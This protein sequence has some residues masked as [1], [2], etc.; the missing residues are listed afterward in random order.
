MSARVSPDV[1]G[2]PVR[3]LD[4]GPSFSAAWLRA[5]AFA[6]AAL[7][8]LP[9]WQNTPWLVLPLVLFA[10]S[11]LVPFV[12][13]PLA[14]LL[15]IVGSY[16]AIV[17]PGSWAVFPYA[18]GLHLLYVIFALLLSIPRRTDV[19]T[20]V[21]RRTLLRA[22]KIQLLV[23]PGAVVALLVQD[24]GTQPVLVGLACVALAGWAY[25]LVRTLRRR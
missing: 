20:A 3:E 4:I 9:L 21:M 1:K 2:G 19:S 14:S 13:L 10:A 25:L 7:L 16:A 12:L 8:G 15:L 22:G 6:L 5:G 24:A 11:V 18:A 17:Q 23:Q